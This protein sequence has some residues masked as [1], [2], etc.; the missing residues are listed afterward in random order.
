MS[1]LFKSDTAQ[2]TQHKEVKMTG[3][4]KIWEGLYEYKGWSIEFHPDYRIWLMYPEGE[5]GATDAAN[6]KRDAMAMIDEWVS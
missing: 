1:D 3:S 6:T 5:S 4:K 2:H